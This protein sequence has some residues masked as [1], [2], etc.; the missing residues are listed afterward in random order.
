MSEGEE[1]KGKREGK[2]GECRIK[3][4]I[5]QVVKIIAARKQNNLKE[6]T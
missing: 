6:R 2:S 5:K 1:K 3:Q 4:L